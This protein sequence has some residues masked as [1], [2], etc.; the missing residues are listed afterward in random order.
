MGMSEKKKKTILHSI[1]EKKNFCGCLYTEFFFLVEKMRT[2]R[3]F[4]SA[5]NRREIF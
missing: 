4:T 3:V 1:L 5:F 2:E